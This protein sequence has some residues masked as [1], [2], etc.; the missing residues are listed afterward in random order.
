G[1]EPIYAMAGGVMVGGVLQLALQLPALHR[2]RLLPRIAMTWAG[3]RLA[4]SDPA[5][6]QI[7]RLMAPALLGVGVA[8]ISLM[9]NTQI[10]SYLAPGSVTW[11]FYA[12]RL[13]EFPTA[14]LGVA[15][16]VVLT[17]QLAAAKAAGDA[18]RY[19]SMLDWGLRIV[20][21]LAVPSGVALLTFAEPLVATL[22]HHG[23]LQDRDVGQIALALAG[24]GAG[25]VGLVAIKVLAPGYYASQDIRTPVRIA[26]A[27]LVFT[28]LLNI[29]LVPWIAHAGLALSIGLG[30]LLNAL[31]LLVGLLRRGSYRPQPGWFKFG[32]QVVAASA[33][34]AIFLIWGA[35]HFDWLALRAT[36]ARR[37]GLLALLL[38]GAAALYFGALAASGLQLRQ[39]FRR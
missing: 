12:D 3:V 37:A 20:V 16:G 11:L 34:L 19:S 17:P 28:Q 32:L 22:F 31:W 25:L 38:A 29:A 27:V 14:L 24:Y 33:L 1:I 2:L 36:S 9:I 10:A 7:L 39:L 23:A 5:V 21:L 4:L 18:D 13:M 6:R 15:L 30:A 26:I 35:Q 8:Q